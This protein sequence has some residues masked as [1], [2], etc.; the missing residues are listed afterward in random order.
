MATKSGTGLAFVII[1]EVTELLLTWASIG[2]MENKM[3][4]T[5]MDYIGDYRNLGIGFKFMV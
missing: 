1:S 4:T 5:I 2:I 3:E